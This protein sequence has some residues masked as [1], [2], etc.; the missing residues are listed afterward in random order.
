M[1]ISAQMI[2]MHRTTSIQSRRFEV[3]R[4]VFWYFSSANGQY[5]CKTDEVMIRSS[6]LHNL[7]ICRRL[8]YYVNPVS[9]SKIELGTRLHP[10]KNINLAILEVFNW[11]SNTA[12]EIFIKLEKGSSHTLEHGTVMVNN[13]TSVTF[14]P[15][16]SNQKFDSSS[17]FGKQAY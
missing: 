4:Q 13:I 10:Y 2:W 9:E 12:H 11:F 5:S 15:Y 7:N 17:E 8:H 3:C 16:N 1:K 6:N 14:E